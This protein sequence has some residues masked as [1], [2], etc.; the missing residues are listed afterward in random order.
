[1]SPNAQLSQK[2]HCLHIPISPIAQLSQKLQKNADLQRS[3]VGGWGGGPRP[4]EICIF[5]VFWHSCAIG[6]IGICKRCLFW[7]SCAFGKISMYHPKPLN[8][9][10]AIYQAILLGS[11]DV[12][13]GWLGRGSKTSGNWY[14][15][16]VF[17]DSCTIGDI[18]ICKRCLF[19]NSC[20]FGKISMYH[21]R[22]LYIDQAIY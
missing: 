11:P 22:L 1:M 9:D 21:P 4:L 7:D 3:W 14:L 6:E 17:W 18:A 10:Q 16:Y 5:C 15:F 19:W 8:I 2:R 20:A 13:G 12:L